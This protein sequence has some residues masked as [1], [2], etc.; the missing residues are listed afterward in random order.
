MNYYRLSVT[1][2]AQQS[3]IKLVC[4]ANSAE[5]FKYL[6]DE[7]IACI[8]AK[9]SANTT[10]CIIVPVGPVA[11]YAYFVER[12]N[13][14]K[15][16]LQHVTFINMDE[17][18]ADADNCVPMTHK[19]SFRAFMER[20]VYSKISS[21]LLMPIEQRIFPDPK[22]LAAVSRK[23]EELGGVDLCIG[24]IGINGHVAFNE[25]QTELSAEE[26]ANLH[27]RVINVSYETLVSNGIADLN[28]A[29]ELMPRYAVTIGINE[30]LS[31]KKIVLGV[32]REWHRAVLRRT[33]CGQVTAAFPA[34]L[35]QQHANVTIVSNDVAAERAISLDAEV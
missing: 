18:M 32:F 30:I 34:T 33:M 23:I 12:V 17:Y 16:N 15:I 31:A 35:L 10:C 21:A 29:L 8:Q 20:E 25:P 7:M 26:F 3:S 9:A 24:G 2:L 4:K 13:Q 11:H 5:A 6:A 28:G 19:L 22:D 1:E 27:T 14:E